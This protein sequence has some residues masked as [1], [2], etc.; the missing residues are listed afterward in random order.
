MKAAGNNL[1]QADLRDARTPGEEEDEKEDSE[2][3]WT[4][5]VDWR[6]RVAA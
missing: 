6:G 2:V 1:E 4:G 3:E 5:E